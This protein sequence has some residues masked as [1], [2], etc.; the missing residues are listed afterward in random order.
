MRFRNFPSSLPTTLFRKG[1]ERLWNQQIGTEVQY[2][3]SKIRVVEG[4]DEKLGPSFKDPIG[5]RLWIAPP[6]SGTVET[7][8]CEHWESWF[9]RGTPMF[10]IC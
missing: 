1:Q 5:L 10:S 8:K 7:V 9:S 2:L 6:F 3:E 4:L